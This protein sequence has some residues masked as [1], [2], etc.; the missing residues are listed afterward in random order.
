MH[1]NI[2]LRAEDERRQS[3][4]AC[5]GRRQLGLVAVEIFPRGVPSTRR[6]L[7]GCDKHI[8]AV[9]LDRAKGAN[10]S[11]EL[12]ALLCVRGCHLGTSAGAACRL[13]GTE[14]PGQAFENTARSEQAVRRRDLDPIA[15]NDG[16]SPTGV[17]VLLGLDRKA[18][19]IGSEQRDVVA[20]THRKQLC[21]FPTEHKAGRSVEA[22]ICAVHELSVKTGSPDERPV[23]ETRQKGLPCNIASL[24]GDQLRRQRG[25]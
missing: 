9:V 8:G 25:G 22:V 7:L 18:L 12:H 20:H 6:R 24:L 1:L 19:L 16:D 17:H 2:L 21:D 4:T 5:N 15:A 11:T 23:G 10:G 14:R 3:Q 13:G